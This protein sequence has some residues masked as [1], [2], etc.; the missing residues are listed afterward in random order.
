M[1]LPLPYYLLLTADNRLLLAQRSAN[2]TAYVPLHWSASFEEQVTEQDLRGGDRVF[3]L[4]VQRGVIEEFGIH[5]DP[6]RIH[7]LSV[8]LELDNLNLAVV[9][10]VEAAQTLEQIHRSWSGD[11]RPSHAWEAETLDGIEAD[12]AALDALASGA[13]FRLA[14]LHPTSRAR[15]ALLARWLRWRAGR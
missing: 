7:V 6:S 9:A 15:C 11:P 5:V 10:L 8:L 12:L 14:P 2:R 1:P 3:H 13:E 4:A